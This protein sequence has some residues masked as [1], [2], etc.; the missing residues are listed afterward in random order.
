MKNK[1]L[2]LFALLFVTA[3]VNAQS[4][5]EPK[6]P[7]E[8][9]D[10][11]SGTVYRVENVDAG[12]FLSGGSS[13]YSW[14]TS[15][16]LV[17]AMEEEPLA[18][19]LTQTANGWTFART[20]DSKYTFISGAHPTGEGGLK[21]GYGE[22]HVD[23]GSQGHNYFELLKQDNGCYHIRAVAS[24]DT[25]GATMEDYDVKCWGWEGEE[26]DYPTAVYA[27]VV[28]SETMHCDWVF[29]TDSAFNIYQAKIAL[30][31]LAVAIEEEG[32]DVDYSQF[33]SVYN[34]DDIDALNAAVTKLNALMFQAR[35]DALLS[36]ASES[37]PVD[38]SPLINNPEFFDCTN[39][40]FPG[41]TISAPNGGNTWVNGTDYVEYW[42]EN[43][44]NGQFDYYQE[45]VGLP[46]G[47]YTLTA[48][49]WNSMNGVAGE[50]KATSGVYGTSS[51]GTANALVDVDCDNANLHEYT[52]GSVILLE[53]DTLR[54]GVKNFETMVARWFGVDYIHLTYYGPVSDDPDKILLDERIAQLENTYPDVD[55]LRANQAVK[56]NYTE[57]LNAAMDATEDFHDHLAALNAAAEALATSVKDYIRLNALIESWREK[58]AYVDGTKWADAGNESSD[59]FDEMQV[60]YESGSYTVED[61]DRAENE[62]STIFATIISSLVEKGD[63]ITFLLNNAG[64]NKDFSGWSQAEG[65]ATPFFGGANVQIPE[66]YPLPELAGTLV[67]GGCAEVFQAKFDIS[68]TIKNMPAGVFTLSC[69]A[70]ARDDDN[71]GIDA[72]LFAI[73]GD[74]SNIQTVKIQN[75]HNEVSPIQLYWSDIQADVNTSPQNGNDA[76]VDGGYV[77]NGMNGANV[78]FRAGYYKNFFNIELNEPTDITVGIRTASS[79]E[80]VL[81]D[82]F[83]IVYKGDDASAYKET[84]EKLL[85]QVEDLMN[86]EESTM[87]MTK[88]TDKALD[89]VMGEGYD[90]LDDIDEAT[91]EEAIALIQKL[92]QTIADAKESI[93]KVQELREYVVSTNDYRCDITS[94][95]NELIPMLGDVLALLEEPQGIEKNA[96]VEKY[97]VDLK[98]AYTKFVQ[99]DWLDATE[100]EPAD[101]TAVIYNPDYQNYYISEKAN[102]KGWTVQ[103]NAGFYET[104][105][106][107]Y[108]QAYDLRQ[109]IYGLAP[110][111]YRLY[112][113]GFYRNG[114]YADVE[115]ALNAASKEETDEEATEEPA[116]E[117]RLVTLFAGDARTMMLP[118]SADLVAYNELEGAAGATITVNGESLVIAN[119]MEQAF[120]AFENDLYQNVLQFEVSEGQKVVEIGLNKTA[121]VGSDWT[122][123]GAWTLEYL[124]TAAP[125]DDAT[126]AVKGIED[127]TSTKVVIYNL[128]GQRVAKAQKGVYIINGKKIVVK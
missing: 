94:S 88:E 32:L 15:T 110:G 61:I 1:L 106:E 8:G 3:G 92:E 86:D 5:T 53:N 36:D 67:D 127:E 56:D 72:E 29:V 99:C 39:G 11:V 51:L 52:T 49:M 64:F 46:A 40:N 47:K 55:D 82:D 98:T 80:W 108:N 120:F 95:D 41:W 27:T 69:Q 103:G 118:I 48:S 109:S 68:Q 70:F 90:L 50:F 19:T 107:F 119:N 111:H 73:V 124:G 43:P 91:K 126:T 28:P 122:M 104:A 37:N 24:D 83:K 30:Y 128:A 71:N 20:T 21:D 10:P 34:S 66:D 60:G 33:E 18:F 121:L 97:M 44:V 59:I 42:N 57:T 16:V 114:G 101:I 81:F 125:S 115:K 76:S 63:D 105:A 87:N 65:S 79:G 45:L 22:M 78:Y 74:S 2:S 89:G 9:S 35:V 17:N 113:P 38:A 116:T 112:V 62:I 14:A 23:M 25:Y 13:W 100:S 77:P 102:L 26:S 93:A 54:I 75:L 6:A 7:S 96:D 58:I 117:D 85:A 84:I 123:F 4:W 31:K 12:Q